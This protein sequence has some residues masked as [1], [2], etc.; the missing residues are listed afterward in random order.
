MKNVMVLNLGSTS[1]K[2]KLFDMDSDE[3]ML[4]QGSVDAIGSEES[5]IQ[6]SAASGKL[7]VIGKCADHGEAFDAA[8][9]QLKM[10]GILNGLDSLYAVGYKA[11]LAGEVHGPQIITDELIEKMESFCALAPAHNPVYITMMKRV[12]EMYPE[13]RQYGCFETAFH[14]SVP[15]KRRAYGVPKEWQDWGVIRF[16]FHGSSHSYIA[17]AIG[18]RMPEARKVISIHLGGSSSMCAIQDGKSVATTMGATPQSGLFHNNRTGDLDVFC[19]PLLIKRFGSTEAA[20]K[21]LSSQSGFLGLSGVSN[22]L[23][24]VEAA[25]NEGNAQAQEAIDA[26]CDEIIGFVGMYTAY[27]QGLDAIC[28]TGG[29]G[30]HSVLVRKTVLEALGFKGVEMNPDANDRHDEIIS[31][32]KSRVK[33]FVLPTNEEWMIAQQA[34]QCP[35]TK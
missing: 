25:A 35:W 4:A 15:M 8:M 32:D 24:K 22:D 7:D 2:Y 10:L 20:L 23:R 30:E 3:K 33:V 17:S 6:S 21:A 11:V 5:R 12:R 28:F 1:F 34:D 31:T 19:L 18:Q 27:M 9:Q 14:S 13:L 26:F 16:G 29:I